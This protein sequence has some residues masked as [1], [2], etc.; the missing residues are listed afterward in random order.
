MQHCQ[1]FENFKE[2]FLSNWTNTEKPIIAVVNGFALGGGCEMAMMS[3]IIYAGDKA[4]FGQ[5]Q[6]LLLKD[7]S[8]STD[9]PVSTPGQRIPSWTTMFQPRWIESRLTLCVRL[10]KTEN[11]GW[12]KPKHEAPRIRKKIDKVPWYQEKE[13][14]GESRRRSSAQEVPW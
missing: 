3:D 10:P 13:R 1:M 4:K 5:P 14:F 7:W 11:K 9:D 8:N 6:I 12:V 2:D